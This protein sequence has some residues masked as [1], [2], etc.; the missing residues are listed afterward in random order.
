MFEAPATQFRFMEVAVVPMRCYGIVKHPAWQV[1]DLNGD[2]NPDTSL[3]SAVAMSDGAYGDG[4]GHTIPIYPNWQNYIR[5]INDDAGYRYAMSEGMLWINK[6]YDDEGTTPQAESVISGGNFVAWDYETSTH[7]HL[8][9]HNIM[10]DTSRLVPEIDNWQF[11]PYLYW[12]MSSYNSAG[13]SL[14]VGNGNDVYV[15]LLARTEL[16]MHKKYLEVFPRGYAYTFSGVEVYQDG[17]RWWPESP[18][19]VP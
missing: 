10:S 6:H 18:T 5:Q 2:G 14:K 11:K 9:S 13:Q 16:W 7:V 15:P 3:P 8:V 17:L 1:V 4:K 19:V 12:K